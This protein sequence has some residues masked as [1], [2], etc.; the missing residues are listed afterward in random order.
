[1]SV[2]K[3]SVGNANK[4]IDRSAQNK[5]KKHLGLP[6]NKSEYRE[7]KKSASCKL[8][9][10]YIYLHCAIMN[11]KMNINTPTHPKI[12]ESAIVYLCLTSQFS[13]QV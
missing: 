6:K 2:N 13:I 12:F 3:L 9:F 5:L 10:A 7:D 1:M 11:E 8:K 4:W